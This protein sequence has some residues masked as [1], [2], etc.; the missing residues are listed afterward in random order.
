V[1]LYGDHGGD[2]LTGGR[3]ADLFAFASGSGRDTITDFDFAAG[4]RVVA[5]GLPRTVGINARGEV[6]ITFTD[7]DS[8][9]LSNV[10]TG[11][12]PISFFVTL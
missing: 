6:V 9:T 11:Q 10:T 7:E 8:V 12:L 3:G 1:T 2:V 4:D 5:P